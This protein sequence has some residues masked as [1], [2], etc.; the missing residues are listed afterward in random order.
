MPEGD[1]IA[2]HARRI[3]PALE[4][5][6]PVAVRTHPRFSRDRWA[7]RLT[8]RTIDRVDTRGKHLLVRFEGGLTVHSHLGMVGSWGVYARGRRW[9]R[10]PRRAWLV[11][12]MGGVDVVEFDGSTLE[13]ITDGRSR[14]DQRLAALGPDVLAD[15]FDY[16]ECL[17]RLRLDDPTRP[18][19]DALIDQRTVAGIGNMWKCEGCWE[20]EIDPWRPAHTVSDD[21]VRRIIELVRPRMQASAQDIFSIEKRVYGRLGQRCPRCGARIESRGQWEDNRLTYWC[22]GCQH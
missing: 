18:I 5:Q 20:A 12:D 2:W 22:P 11:M 9:G 13:L 6:A 8:G 3:R 4:G 19:G 21:E 7:E 16:E 17:R 1:T 14:F 10:S 15:A